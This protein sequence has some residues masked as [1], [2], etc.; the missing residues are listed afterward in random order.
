MKVIAL[1][2]ALIFLI[3]GC[4]AKKMSGDI[5]PEEAEGMFHV[6]HRVL[7]RDAR[8]AYLRSA[9]S[10]F[11][12]RKYKQAEKMVRKA[13]LLDPRSGIAYTILGNICFDNYRFKE[14]EG[15][16]RKAIEYSPGELAPYSALALT[17][18]EFKR[19]NDAEKVI[20]NCLEKYPD[21]DEAYAILASICYEQ[22]KL[23]KAQDMAEKALELNPRAASAHIVL[24][25]IYGD[26]YKYEK[27][28]RH[29]MAAKQN[30]PEFE[31][32]MHAGLGTIL[33]KKKNFDSAETAFKKALELYPQYYC[34]WTQLGD[35]YCRK[36]EYDRA[37][38]VLKKAI[39]VYPDYEDAYYYMGNLMLK[40]GD[41]ASAE[42]YYTRALEINPYNFEDI[43][44][45]LARVNLCKRKTQKAK[46]M[47]KKALE[48]NPESAR[49]LVM[50]GIVFKKE[51]NKNS[52]IRDFRKAMELDP[53]ND[54]A[55]RELASIMIENGNLKEAGELARSAVNINPYSALNYFVLSHWAKKFGLDE[56]ANSA[57]KK[58]IE[59]NPDITG[60]VSR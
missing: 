29:Y 45:G 40:K 3:I 39:E 46:E 42:K 37:M 36:G 10:L 32:E 38:T 54:D 57:L 11:T 51:D 50:R 5:S 20:Y 24:A 2:L 12:E 48:I 27:A 19:Y 30:D 53:A 34:A 22:R 31:M 23:D 16:Y 6:G 21:N 47:I 33:L 25:E 59:I 8:D 49:A 26:R 58:A 55:R 1:F 43:Y 7:R 13:L 52:A 4:P 14:A 56:K 44:L 18:L 35:L 9:Q 17:L 15:A 60:E 28:I 41:V